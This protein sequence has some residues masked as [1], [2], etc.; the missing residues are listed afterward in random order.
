M[1]WWMCAGSAKK[2]ETEPVLLWDQRNRPGRHSSAGS[3][4]RGKDFPRLKINKQTH[5]S[6]IVYK[7]K[8]Q[9]KYH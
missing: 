6:I 4:Q 5:Q 9:A 3:N 7:G 2:G 1:V 8:L